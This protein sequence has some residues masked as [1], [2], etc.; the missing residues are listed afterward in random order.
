MKNSR[1]TVIGFVF[2]S[3]FIV[4]DGMA[5][6]SSPT[7][8]TCDGYEY[9]NDDGEIL[10]DEISIINQRDVFDLGEQVTVFVKILE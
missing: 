2:L 10:Y 3:F 9:G 6:Y 8:V 5:F 7:I 1:L 4:G